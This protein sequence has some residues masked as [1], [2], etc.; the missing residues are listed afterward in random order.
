MTPT[1]EQIAAAPTITLDGLV[2]VDCG[3]DVFIVAQGSEIVSTTRRLQ[4]IERGLDAMQQRIR[5]Y[6]SS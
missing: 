1:P 4:E 2:R 5:S 6:Q 3:D